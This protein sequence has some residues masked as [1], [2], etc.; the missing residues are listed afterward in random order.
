M[1]HHRHVT[2]LAL[3]AITSLTLFRHD[4]RRINVE[5]EVRAL[6]GAQQTAEH[7]A[8]YTLQPRQP[9]A[10]VCAHASHPIAT[11]VAAR[12]FIQA[13]NTTQSVVTA[14]NAQVLQRPPA[15]SEHQDKRRDVRRRI[16]PGGT[17]STGQFMVDEASNAHRSQILVKQDQSRVRRQR[18]VARRQLE[19]QNRL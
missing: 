1:P 13:D 5:R 17:A 15:T 4:L 18:F 9:S 8:V 19:R 3:I 7:A 10:L 11:G 16:I 14:Q 2:L 12:H 6:V